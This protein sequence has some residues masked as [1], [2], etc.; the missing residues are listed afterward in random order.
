MLASEHMR[1]ILNHNL[2]FLFCLNGGAVN[3]KSFNQD[4]VADSTMKTKYIAISEA[5]KEVVCIKNFVSESGVVPSASS[6][7][8]LYCDNNGAIA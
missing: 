5:A 2:F 6:T 3:W 1:M 4:T 8:D 7:I